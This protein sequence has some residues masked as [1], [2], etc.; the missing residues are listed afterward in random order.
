[1][2][3]R[4]LRDGLGF[5]FALWLIGYALG[6]LFFALVP[7]AAI[8]WYVMPIGIVIAV[9]VLRRWIRLDTMNDA[10]RIGVVWTLVAIVCD[11]VFLVRLLH[12]AGGYYKFDVYL[13]Y[14]VTL[15]LPVAVRAWSAGKA[16]G[17]R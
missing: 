5:G 12:P 9:I 8:G 16:D 6:F 17:R 15:V 13:Y 4:V 14:L 11:Y 2:P 1:M 10:L 7:P 3:S